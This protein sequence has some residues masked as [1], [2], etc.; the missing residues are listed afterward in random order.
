MH[1]VVG[2]GVFPRSLGNKNLTNTVNYAS[3]VRKKLGCCIVYMYICNTYYVCNSI[4]IVS[5]NNIKYVIY[6]KYYY[7]IHIS[8]YSN[9]AKLTTVSLT[10]QNEPHQTN[11]I[12]PW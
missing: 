3:R 4:C 6:H 5:S 12:F 1:K 2:F 10:T 9:L 11:E 8:K 7:Y